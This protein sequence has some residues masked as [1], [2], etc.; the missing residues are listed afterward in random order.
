MRTVRARRAWRSAA[1]RSLLESWRARPRPFARSPP[2]GPHADCA[3]SYCAAA[4]SVALRVAA[5]GLNALSCFGKHCGN[6][7]RSN[8]VMRDVGGPR[9][10]QSMQ[11]MRGVPSSCLAV[12]NP[13]HVKFLAN[14]TLYQQLVLSKKL[15]V[16]SESEISV[17]F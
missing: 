14:D 16:K 17:K 5:R 11:N 7:F 8:V 13:C 3:T 1:Q 12:R 6:V 10:A 4:T 2:R 9:T 15:K